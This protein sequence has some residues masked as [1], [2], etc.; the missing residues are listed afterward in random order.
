MIHFFCSSPQFA[1]FQPKIGF[2]SSLRSIFFLQR[3]D[4]HSRLM[5]W[6]TQQ[7]VNREKKR[8]YRI[9]YDISLE[10]IVWRLEIRKVFAI[11]S[12]FF[13]GDVFICVRH[14]SIETW[15]HN[16]SSFSAFG[17]LDGLVG[18]RVCVCVAIECRIEKQK[19]QI[20]VASSRLLHLP[21]S[22]TNNNNL[23]ELTLCGT[24]FS[25]DRTVVQ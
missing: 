12:V 11:F 23:M 2:F 18:T 16:V 21:S 4:Q 5:A 25:V 7:K 6:N 22:H 1:Y 24:C 14:P 17:W 20:W 8:L 15:F 9:I 13:S 10:S 3:N 19:L